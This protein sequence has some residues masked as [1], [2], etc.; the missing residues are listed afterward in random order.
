MLDGFLTAQLAFYLG[1]VYLDDDMHSTF[2]FRTEQKKEI[3]QIALT[4]CFRA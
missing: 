4:L 3:W 1:L 2:Y